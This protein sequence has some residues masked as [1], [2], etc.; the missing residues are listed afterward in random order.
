MNKTNYE[1]S[2]E[3]LVS[4]ALRK[5]IKELK[6]H[7]KDHPNSSVVQEERLIPY[8]EAQI[9][10][11]KNISKSSK[12]PLEQFLCAL[13][14]SLNTC[15]LHKLDGTYHNR[16]VVS[17]YVIALGAIVTTSTS[18]AV[19]EDSKSIII[20]EQNQDKT[21]NIKEQEKID[22]EQQ[23]EQEPVKKREINNYKPK[24]DYAKVA[25]M[26]RVSECETYLEEYCYYFNFDSEKV[27]LIANTV[28]NNFRNGITINVGTKEFSSTEPETMAIYLVWDL[29]KNG[30]NYAITREE[31][32]ITED[33]AHLQYDEEGNIILRNGLSFSQF[34]GKVNDSFDGDKYLSLAISDRETGFQ[35]SDQAINKNNFGGW[36]ATEAF[37]TFPS[38]EAGIIYH[39]FSLEKMTNSREYNNL[40]EFSGIYN[41][42]DT[43]QPVPE[44]E[45]DV[46]AK[47]YS[48][49]CNE[50][51]Y[52]NYRE[53]EKEINRGKVL[54]MIS[55]N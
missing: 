51:E 17:L 2:S 9:D 38:P 18:S 49:S 55:N 8:L 30:E 42:N 6:K 33:I 52:F 45:E 3:L 4:E 5:T 47:M 13:K 32:T 7:Y 12:N 37:F 46:S 22:K 25:Q 16:F 15:E 14:R 31:L 39:C 21:P 24:M 29:Y 54:A 44:W 53:K 48:Y 36:R 34:I 43:N 1:V 10:C 35:T 23:E 26:K 50:D 11:L 20:K 19:K 27:K 40:L 41:N 28:T